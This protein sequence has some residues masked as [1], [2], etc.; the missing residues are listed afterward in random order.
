M[1][2]ALQTYS[3]GDVV[4]WIDEPTAGAE[5]EHPTPVL[6][7]TAAPAEDETAAPVAASVT[8]EGEDS[9]G[10]GTAYGIAGILLGLAG[11]VAGLLAYRRA[12]GTR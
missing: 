7:L 8:A 12:A 3:D 10:T 6:T 5:P 2:K 9:G 4:R 1:F 11:L